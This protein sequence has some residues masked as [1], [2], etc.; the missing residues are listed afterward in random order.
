MNGSKGVPGLKHGTKDEKGQYKYDT[1]HVLEWNTIA[2]FFDIFLDAKFAKDKVPNADPKKDIVGAHGVKSRGKE[3]FC[4]AWETTWGNWPTDQSFKLEKDGPSR[5]PLEHIADVYPSADPKFKRE[6]F[7]GPQK[8]LNQLKLRF[9]KWNGKPDD[10]KDDWV[11]VPSQLYN[12]KMLAAGIPEKGSLGHYVLND[13]GAAL[14]RLRNVVGVRMYLNDK[15]VRKAMRDVNIRLQ[16]RFDEI[17]RALADP[18]N[19]RSIASGGSSRTGAQQTARTLHPWKILNLGALWD[20]YMNEKWEMAGRH[21]QFVT[22]WEGE[23]RKKYCLAKY[24]KDTKVGRKDSE[25]EQHRKQVTTDLFRKLQKFT[26]ARKNAMSMKFSAPWKAGGR[27]QRPKNDAKF[28]D[29][30][31]PKRPKSN[32]SNPEDSV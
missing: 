22:K 27:T 17:E 25:K 2:Q 5:N 7:T 3:K 26:V 6:E 32:K 10:F 13:P 29:S 1:E 9:F 31:T 23:L 14:L 8:S 24:R 4:T 28:K 20:E 12:E 30:K 19:A 16:D 18:K 11:P 21:E 15:K